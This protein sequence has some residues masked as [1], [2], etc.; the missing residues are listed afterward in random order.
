MN[1]T[2][3][4]VLSF[5][6]ITILCASPY[7]LKFVLRKVHLLSQSLKYLPEIILLIGRIR[8]NLGLKAKA[9]QQVTNYFN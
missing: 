2:W 5:Y 4:S 7:R 3:S 1:T 8:P 9:V 6:E